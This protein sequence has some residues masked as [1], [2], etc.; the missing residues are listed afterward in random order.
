MEVL[1]NSDTKYCR[2]CIICGET[3]GYTNELNEYESIGTTLQ[4]SICNKC[5][6]AIVLLRQAI[7]DGKI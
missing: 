4:K 1:K 5:K 2:I 7:K 6:E 3:H